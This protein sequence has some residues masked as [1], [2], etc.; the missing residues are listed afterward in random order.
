MKKKLFVLSFLFLSVCSYATQ[1]DTVRILGVGNSWTRDSMRWLSAIGKSAGKHVIVGHA[2]LGGSN[3]DDQF[4]GID[5]T[6]YQYKHNGAMQTVHSTYQYWKYNCSNNPVK[7][8]EDK[9]YKN[10]KAGI[11]V[12]LESVVKDESWDYIVFQP[13]ASSFSDRNFRKYVGEEDSM[14]NMLSFMEKIKGMMTPEDSAKVKCGLM[15]PFSNPQGCTSRRQYMKDQYFNGADYEDQDAWNK[16]F[17][18][19]HKLIQNRCDTLALFMG[20]E[21]S[22]MINVG[23]A[24]HEARK[25]DLLTMSGYKL[26]RDLSDTHLA[27]GWPKYLASLCY[28]YA[29]LDIPKLVKF[30]LGDDEIADR[31]Q[32][33]AWDVQSTTVLPTP[34]EIV[35]KKQSTE[36][37]L[38]AMQL[39]MSQ[40]QSQINRLQNTL[41]N[42]PKKAS[43]DVIPA[44]YKSRKSKFYFSIQANLFYSFDEYL[45]SPESKEETGSHFSYA[46]KP[47][48]GYLF[49]RNFTAGLFLIFADCRFAGMNA[50][51]WRYIL[52]NAIIGAGVSTSDYLSWKIQPYARFRIT[53]IFWDRLN[54]W[55]E[56]SMYAGQSIPRDTKTHELIYANTSTIFGAKL[57]PMISCNLNR[58]LQIFTTME[59]ISWNGSCRQYEGST[60]FNNSF[61]FQFIPIYSIL[62]GIFNIGVI[63]RF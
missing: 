4:Y 29:L 33:I 63:K 17:E 36:E 56:F 52:A 43:V 45:E 34:T 51:S 50:N 47:A 7:T 23:K 61:N 27:E 32:N 24:V 54:L 46:I 48:F 6:L 1:K 10:G 39:Q 12:T 37:M 59:F 16:A 35:A 3:L 55:A 60:Q 2:Y 20:K 57:R 41:E 30:D 25:D 58:N 5:D 19:Y 49:S 40:L 18:H 44:K 38:L 9:A 15:M 28:A 14:F 22:F 26:Q 42:P 53:R 11:G 21:C 8:P 31:A 62:S 13:S